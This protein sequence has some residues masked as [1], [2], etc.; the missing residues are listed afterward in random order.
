M[1]VGLA[2]NRRCDPQS[3]RCPVRSFR[4]FARSWR[5]P[6]LEGRIGSRP[7]TVANRLVKPVAAQT[8]SDH[9]AQTRGH[10]AVI[11]VTLLVAGHRRTSR[12]GFDTADLNE[13]A[14]SR[15]ANDRLPVDSI[16]RWRGQEGRFGS[17]P[18]NCHLHCRRAPDG[19]SDSDRQARSRARYLATTCGAMPRWRSRSAA[20]RMPSNEPTVPLVLGGT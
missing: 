13:A 17:T 19:L 12:G 6:S 5:D 20:V 4:G 10:R 7:R 14:G 18:A 15:C 8:A 9:P 3:A 1:F 11:P 2:P 16:I